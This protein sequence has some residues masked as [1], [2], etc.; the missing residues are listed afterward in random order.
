MIIFKLRRSKTGIFY[1]LE[2]Y[3][4]FT[5]NNVIFDNDATGCNKKSMQILKAENVYYMDQYAV[6]GGF[7]MKKTTPLLGKCR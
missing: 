1:Y 6:L 5:Q 3:F 7:F 2:E 4:N